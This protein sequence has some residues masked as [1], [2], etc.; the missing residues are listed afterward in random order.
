[1]E[2]VARK[3]FSQELFRKMNILL[4]A[5]V[6]IFFVLWSVVDNKEKFKHMIYT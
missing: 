5:S 1:M 6:L 4:L 3:V 2:G